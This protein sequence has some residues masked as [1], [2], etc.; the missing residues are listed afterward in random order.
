MEEPQNDRKILS[1]SNNHVMPQIDLF[2]WAM[3]SIASCWKPNTN[4]R[5]KK[6]HVFKKIPKNFP[7]LLKKHYAEIIRFFQKFLLPRM[8]NLR[9]NSDSAMGVFLRHACLT[10]CEL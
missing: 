3:T 4:F 9:E 2:L 7:P 1:T 10:Q 5:F 8:E 6:N